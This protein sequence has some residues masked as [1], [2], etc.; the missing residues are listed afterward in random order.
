MFD[1]RLL[2][3]FDSTLGRRTKFIEIIIFDNVT[4]LK[5]NA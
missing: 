1:E 5:K 4:D 2:A 3:I